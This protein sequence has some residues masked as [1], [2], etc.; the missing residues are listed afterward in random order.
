MNNFF[1]SEDFDWKVRRIS[2][3]DRLVR[4]SL[5]TLGL[6]IDFRSA[7]FIDRI[8]TR[9]MRRSFSP[10]TSGVMTNI[11]QRM[12][13]YHLVSQVLIYGVEGDLVELGCN[14]GESSVLIT[15]IMQAHGSKKKLSVYDSFEGLPPLSASDGTAF[16]E[17]GLRTTED[18][19]RHNFK[20]YNLP[21]PE[22]HKGWFKDTLPGG[23][24]EKICFAYL[25]GDFYDSI[26]VSLEH[27]YPRMTRGAICLIDDYCDPAV[28]PAGWNKLP[29]VKKACDEYLRDKPEKMEFIYSG[30]YSH[31]FFRKGIAPSP[32]PKA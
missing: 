32:I 14:S 2:Y 23:L 22:I 17:G 3:L 20:K 25:D 11:E 26:L 7:Q 6:D 21:L 31:A 24:P 19:V 12:N 4:R 16:Q 9:L 8:A 18:V 1:I 30:D 27:V 29:G 15:K 5:R 10:V 13:M 28:N